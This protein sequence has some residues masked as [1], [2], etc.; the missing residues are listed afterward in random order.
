MKV[1]P[2]KYNVLFHLKPRDDHS[3]YVL[4][5]LFHGQVDFFSP[6]IPA[7]FDHLENPTAIDILIR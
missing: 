4:Q 3:I 2:S 1:W 6:P 7:L 5:N